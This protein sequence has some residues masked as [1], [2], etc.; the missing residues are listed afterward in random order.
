MQISPWEEVAID[1]IDPWTIK[2]NGR[3][4][5]FNALTC[6]D[7]ASNLV[8]LIRMTIRPQHMFM[9]CLHSAGFSVT[10]Y[11]YVAYMIKE[12]NSLAVPFNGS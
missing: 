2:V 5:E 10:P 6:I 12:E 7:T 8:E 4:V 3:Q 9:T 1:L 11:Q